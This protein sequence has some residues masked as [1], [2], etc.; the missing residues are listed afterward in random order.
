M[1]CV[2]NIWV[3]IYKNGNRNNV[4]GPEMEYFKVPF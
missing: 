1:D 3:W 2:K 4:Y